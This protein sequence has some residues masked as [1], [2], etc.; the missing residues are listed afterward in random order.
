MISEKDLLFMQYWE[1]Q[2][3]ALGTTRS[4]LLRGLPMAILFALPILLFI[5]CVWVFFPDWYAKVSQ[6]S[7]AMF[8]TAIFALLLIVL[9]YSFFRMHYKWELNE[10]HY[11]ALKKKLKKIN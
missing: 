11:Q 2:R 6:T 1:N 3:A 10:Q 5:V 7:P 4:K 9:F 8:V